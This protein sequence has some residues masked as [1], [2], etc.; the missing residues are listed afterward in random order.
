MPVVGVIGGQWGDE[1]KGKIVDLLAE[2][3]DVVARFSGGNNAGHTV[4][5]QFGKFALHL[6]PSGIFSP[7]AVCLIGNGVV[8]DPTALLQEIA[9]LK[10]HGV[11]MGRLFISNRAHLIMP[12]HILL[13]RLEEA[14]RGSGAI[15]TTG[16]GIGP[17]FTDKTARLGIR[18]GDLLDKEAFRER[19]RFVLDHKNKVLTRVFGAEPLPFDQVYS[20]F[21]EYGQTLAGFV[22]ETEMVIA[23]ALDK[24]RWVL[25]EGAQG[26]MLDPDFGTYPYVTS[27]SPLMG[28]ACLGAGVPPTKIDRVLGVYKAYTTRVGGGPMPTELTNEIGDCIRE[29]GHEY[30][31]TTGRP[32]RCGW[33]DGVAASYSARLN[34]LTGIALTRLDILDTFESISVCIAYRAN[35]ATYHRPPSSLALLARCEPVYE[36]VPGWR[37]PTGQARDFK[38][39]PKAAQEYVRTLERVVGC[40]VDIISVGAERERTIFVSELP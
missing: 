29:N 18:M 24:K 39:L 13:D 26:A 2:R 31:A 25:L 17:A 34:G 40:P 20:Q 7:R 15:G 16:R 10:A 9:D 14:S 4:I 37:Q 12:Y 3:A 23:E 30:G 36:E 38:D 11:D 5:N 27:S 32:R 6:I 22:R 1:G 19:L 28:Q 33:F 8:I 35:G 21:V